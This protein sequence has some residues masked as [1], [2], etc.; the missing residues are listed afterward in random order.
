MNELTTELRALE[1]HND[2]CKKQNKEKEDDR[3]I[4]FEN[5]S[6]EDME[7]NEYEN[8]EETG[9]ADIDNDFVMSPR[10]I[11]FLEEAW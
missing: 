6:E 2:R 9:E 11:N 5:K 10:D 3:N 7:A 8:L 1:E 4:K